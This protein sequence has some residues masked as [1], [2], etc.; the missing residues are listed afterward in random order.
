VAEAA[1]QTRAL[2]PETVR[3]ETLGFRLEDRRRDALRQTSWAI[4][5]SCDH[6]ERPAVMVETPGAEEVQMA[7]LEAALPTS[8]GLPASH[9]GPGAERVVSAGSLVRLVRVEANLRF[10]TVAVAEAGGSIGD[11]IR[12][13][14]VRTADR[15]GEPE[16][17]LI[18]T[19]RGAN[20]LELE[21]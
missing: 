11:R 15:A 17:F 18:A 16:Q 19:I 3:P 14:L 13:R 10:D 12:V 6:P 5:R 7:R 20:L 8:Q 2:D 4:V 1:L 21:P 9:G